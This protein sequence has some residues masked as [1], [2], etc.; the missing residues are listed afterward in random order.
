MLKIAKKFIIYVTFSRVFIMD[1]FISQRECDGLIKA[2]DSHVTQH[3]KH[4]PIV[5]FSDAQTMRRYLRQAGMNWSEHVDE[6][7]FLQ[8]CFET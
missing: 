8:G 3:N 6:K 2:H 7:D 4:Q 5:C 1:H